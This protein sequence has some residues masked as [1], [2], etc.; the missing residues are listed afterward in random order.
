MRAAKTQVFNELKQEYQTLK[1]SWGGY[2][3]YDHW[4]AEDL[5]NAQIASVVTYAERVPEFQALL[6]SVD[7][8]L[9]R[10]YQAV[11]KLAAMEKDQRAAELNKW[12][13]QN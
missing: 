6:K 1:Q 8:D 11:K 9:D 10:F 5:N 4:F 13:S 3:G 2:D 7:Q 12:S